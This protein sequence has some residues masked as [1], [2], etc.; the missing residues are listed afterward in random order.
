[1]SMHTIVD[2]VN[3]IKTFINT[4]TL[5]NMADVEL[6]STAERAH[7]VNSYLVLGGVYYRVITPISIGDEIVTTG[8]FRNV[9]QVTVGS[10]MGRVSGVNDN[11]A[12]EEESTTAEYAHE[13]GAYFMMNNVLYKAISDI[14]IGDTIVTSG[15]EANAEAVTVGEE[16]EDINTELDSVNTSLASKVNTSDIAN[17]LTTTAAG[18]V[19][20]ARQGKVLGDEVE[21]LVNVYG[22]KNILPNELLSQSNYYGLNITVNSDKSVTIN[23]T[24]ESSV[25]LFLG[26]PSLQEGKTYTLSGCPEGV[27]ANTFIDIQ[28]I[29]STR[30]SGNGATFVATAEMSGVSARIRI[31][32]GQVCNNLT[33][34]PM[35]RDARISDDTYVPYAMTNQELT[36]KVTVNNNAGSHNSIYRAINLGQ[37]VS[38]EQWAQIA[39]GTFEDMYIG[40][41]WVIN[42][43]TWRIAAFDYWLKCGDQGSGCTTHHVVIVPDTNLLA[44]N[45]STTH[46]M[47]DQNTTEG[48]YLGSGFFSGTQKGG[49]TNTAKAD[50]RAAIQN[51]FGSAHILTHREYFTNAVVNGKPSGGTWVNSDVDCM[52]ERMVY[53]NAVFE[54]AN[55]GTTIPFLHTIDKSQLPLFAFNPALIC[56]HREGWWLRDVVSA[57][58]FPFVAYYGTCHATNASY[59]WVGIRPVFGIC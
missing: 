44:P 55:D 5:A 45:G 42:G 11:I 18:K 12:P 54:P 29:P 47:N 48:G 49:G 26:V 1:M 4:K 36:K 13:T 30:D 20:D 33:F 6:T 23:G 39:A 32:Q 21:A 51:A 10:E 56:N 28:D 40:D 35:I 31:Q 25:G 2:V 57:T 9:Q 7:A 38:S 34:Y 53:G 3:A 8:N 43:V 19:L 17:N 27:I 15:A 22:S 46:Y 24:A 59:A 37:S 50:C 58:D 41:Y 52:N 16:L 14:D